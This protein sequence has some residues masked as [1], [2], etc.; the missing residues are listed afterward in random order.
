MSE[1][2]E[3]GFKQTLKDNVEKSLKDIF[4]KLKALDSAEE[5]ERTEL[6]AMLQEFLLTQ[7]CLP[8]CPVI[9]IAAEIGGTSVRAIVDTGASRSHVSEDIYLKIKQR[10]LLGLKI[11]QTSIT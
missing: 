10:T 7:E 11:S 2:I 6:N 9:R 5:I 8:S 1:D 3:K 4:A